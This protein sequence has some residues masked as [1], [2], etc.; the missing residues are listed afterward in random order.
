MTPFALRLYAEAARQEPRTLAR[1]LLLHSHLAEFLRACAAES[2]PVIVLKGAVL[3]ETVYPRLGLRDFRDLDVLVRPADAPRAR[4]VLENLGYA[5]DET[6]WRELLAGH[7]GQADFAKQTPAGPIVLEL[8]TH[9]VNNDLFWGEWDV[10]EDALWRRSLPV[11]LA[12]A[13]ARVLGPEDQLLHLCLHLAGHYLSAPRSLADIQH[14]CAAQPI[15]WPLLSDLAR[16]SGLTRITY[17]GLW[18]AACLLDA[19]IPPTALAA[20]APRPRRLLERFALAR[21]QDLTARRTQ[22]LRLPLLLLLS[23]RPLRQ[24]RLLRRLLFPSR[25]WLRDH[26]APPRQTV[27]LPRLYAAHLRALLRGGRDPHLPG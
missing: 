10:D 25:R 17:T 12:S 11:L 16:R 5:A 21:A 15:D 19:A 2:L 18:L 27:P 20:L 22:G 6:H 24:P 26:Y 23:D 9:L 1:T 4:V 7:D 14:V 8:H 3:A 13:P